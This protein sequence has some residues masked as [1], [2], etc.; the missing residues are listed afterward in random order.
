MNT[1][2]VGDLVRSEAIFKDSNGNQYDPSNVYC[3]VTDPDGNQHAYQYGV[4]PEIIKDNTGA[5]HLDINVTSA[6]T[7]C[8]SWKS[9]GNGQ[10]VN[11]AKFFAKKTCSG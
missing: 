5:Y 3:T 9:T 7:W 8:Y 11:A 4:N 1:Y 6:G 2:H 10:A